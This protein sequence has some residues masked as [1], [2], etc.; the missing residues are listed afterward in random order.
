MMIGL[1][2]L[3]NSTL[4]IILWGIE[5]YLTYWPWFQTFL[6]NLKLVKKHWCEFVIQG[7]VGRGYSQQHLKNSRPGTFIIRF[8]ENKKGKLAVDFVKE[9]NGIDHS[10]ISIDNGKYGLDVADT[11]DDMYFDT[12][13]EL[14][15]NVNTWLFLYRDGK[16]EKVPT[17]WPLV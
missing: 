3:E 16:K 15:M 12:L 4:S 17:A 8:T 2:L 6:Q 9:E 1:E 14:I 13:E 7:L 11:S 10:L 5:G